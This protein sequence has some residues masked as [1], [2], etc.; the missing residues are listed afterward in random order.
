MVGRSKPHRPNL[1]YD[2]PERGLEARTRKQKET[3]DQ[4][5]FHMEGVA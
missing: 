3:P 5:V 4:T 1:Q 2:G